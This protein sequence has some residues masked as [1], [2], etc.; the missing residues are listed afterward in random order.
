MQQRKVISTKESVH[1][2]DSL[3]A[4]TNGDHCSLLPMVIIAKRLPQ[5]DD[6]KHQHFSITM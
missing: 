6:A 5:T 3:L 1:D 4:A 2:L